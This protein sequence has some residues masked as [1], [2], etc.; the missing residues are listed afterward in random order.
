MTPAQLQAIEKIFHAALDHEPDQVGAFLDT[1]CT[2]DELLRVQVQSLLTSHRRAGDFIET[3]AVGLA[4]KIIQNAETDLLVG[5]T[6]GHYRILERIG[7]GGMGE[8]YLASD[9]TAGRKAAL[10]LLPSRFTGDARRLIQFQQEARAVVGLNHPNILTVYEIGEDDS[11]HYIASELIEGETLRQHLARGRMGLDEALEV[12]IQ[13]ATALAAAHQ[14]GIV[15]RDIKPENI[16]LRPDGYVKVLDFGIA[17][18]A[19][20]EVPATMAEEEAVLL[21]ETNLGPI[22]GTVR[23]MSPEQARGAPVDKRTDIWSLGV[24]LYEMVSGQAPFTGD[25]PGE[26]MASILGT[27]PP[28][29]SSIAQTPAELQ[30]I[31]TKALRKERDQRYQSAHELLEVLK[32]F[33]RGME[34]KAELERATVAPLWLRSARSPTALMLVLLVTALTLALPFYWHGN[35]TTRPAPEKSIA[36]LPFE[37]LSDNKENAYF[38]AGVQDEILSD[39]AKIA[40]LKVISRTSTRPYEAGKPRKSRQIGQELGVAHLLEGNVQRIGNRV[41]INAQLIDTRTDSHLWAQTY[42]RDVADLFAI[43][44]EIAQ[45]IAGQLQAKISAGE[46]AAVTRP[47]TR[48]L[49]ANDLYLK[50]IALESDTTESKSQ[51]EVIRLLEQVVA[52]DPRFLRAYC[53]LARLHLSLYEGEDHTPARLQTA[54]AV[55]EKAA[56]LQPDAGEVHLVRA[57]YLARGLRDYDQARA[58]LELA[59]RTLP[60]DATV[61]FE[62]ALVDVRQGRWTEALRSFER[63]IEPDPRNVKYLTT[64]AEICSNMRRYGEADRLGRR[65]LALSPHDT[66]L[67][68]FLA[69][70][71]LAERADIQPWRNELNAIVSENPDAA[72]SISEDLWSCAIV[73]RDVAAAERALATIPPEGIQAYFGAVE[74]REWYVGY[75]ARIFDRPETARSA[76]TA[77]RA[78][79]EKQLREK[80]DN[81]LTWTFLGEVKAALG[82]KQEAIEAGQH[83][84]ELW[85]LSRE[86]RWGLRTLRYL[87]MI[88]AWVG[89]KD[90]ALQQLSL[91]AGQP[92][93]VDYGELK[94]SPDWDPLRGDPR[95]EKIVASLTPKAASP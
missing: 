90:L 89:E 5:H 61:Y 73:E 86:P 2:G 92:F 54:I 34:F 93:F 19:E 15:H 57:R 75:T 11:S 49:V 43:Q 33:R 24:V 32:G 74:P 16:M 46:K 85:P 36:V 63:A 45:T 55:I 25:T 4:T 83:A 1:A 23:Y 82:E 65:A 66:W 8:V 17:K 91:Y 27:E 28:L 64:I 76:L 37:N 12:A 41:R 20:Q 26:V 60:N 10:K 95:F 47:P 77:A 30:Q 70:Q 9:I 59:R 94:L 71:P 44:S 53:A 18:L 58:E 87:A 50:A 72:P 88:Y 56:Q 31:V 48:D 67:R 79:L 3:P 80:P 42:D 14:A 13:I 29:L 21:V 22:L 6:I 62:T 69:A 68:I 39:L 38:A 81:A 35:Q 52:R 7:S 51:L 78:I 84:C 40:D